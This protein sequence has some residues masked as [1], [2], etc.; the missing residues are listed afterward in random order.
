MTFSDNYLQP[1][2]IRQDDS[3]GKVT[4]AVVTAAFFCATALTNAV[5][6]LIDTCKGESAKALRNPVG[7]SRVREQQ[8]R[9]KAAR[10][11]VV[12]IELYKLF[13]SRRT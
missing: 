3:V 12:D 7:A 6:W 10:S 5:L 9:T 11:N 8:K 2:H 1:G 13:R 4:E